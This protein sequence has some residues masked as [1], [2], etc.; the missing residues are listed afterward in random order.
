[1]R[2]G[3]QGAPLFNAEDRGIPITERLLPSYLKELG[4]STHL[5][6]K[7]HVGMSRDDHLPTNRGYDSHYGMRGGI[8]DY[9]TYHKVEEWPNGRQ[10]FGRDLFDN[11]TPQ[12]S[13]TRYIVDA[14]TDRA[15]RIINDHN[16]SQPLFLH[17]THNAPHAGNPGASL[18][19]P[20]YKPVKNAHIANPDRRLYAEV[21]NHLDSCI[22]VVVKTLAEK[23]I[24]DDTIIV[25]ASDNGSPTTGMYNNWGINLPFRGKKSTPWEGGVRVPALIWHSSFRPRVWNGLMHVTDWMPTLIAA[26]GGAVSE[27]I[28][29]VSQWDSLVQGG[30]SNRREVLISVDDT[31]VYAAYR[32]GDYK[33]VV[34]NLTG[35]SN[36]YYGASYLVNRRPAPEYFPILKKCDAARA[37]ATLGI[38]LDQDEVQAMRRDTAVVQLDKVRDPTPCVPTESRG[39]LFNIARDP[40]ESHNLWPQATNIAALLTSRLRALWA[41]QM[42][43][44]PLRLDT[45]A[46]P[47]N[48]DYFWTPWIGLTADIN[49]NNEVIEGIVAKT[50][51][52]S[53][54]T[55]LAVMVNCNGTVGIRN[56][57][58]ILRTII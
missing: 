1:M 9:Y 45:A 49:S 55:T 46:D 16:A 19:P 5:V 2:I 39:C 36:G 32:A 10:M 18:Q 43:R 26:A 17:L 29:G 48:F 21:V 37:M 54:N 31:N 28:D 52:S 13:E 11:L 20:L 42:A 27:D 53:T 41:Q 33:I 56:F 38:Y 25:F 23:N 15:V 58:C 44:G 22:G 50:G 4:Y 40:S 7:W 8:V 6:G 24:L 57:L 12:Y 30:E 47:E 14:L 34:G 51:P 3:M 35:V